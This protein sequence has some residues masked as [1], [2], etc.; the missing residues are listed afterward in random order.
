MKREWHTR[1]GGVRYEFTRRTRETRAL[2]RSR[3]PHTDNNSLKPIESLVFILFK[4]ASAWEKSGYGRETMTGHPPRFF[5]F[6][7]F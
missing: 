4:E 3:L 7:Y 6:L 1:E 2:L 5:F